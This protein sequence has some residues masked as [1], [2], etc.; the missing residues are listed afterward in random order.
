MYSVK[1]Y[2]LYFCHFE[3]ANGVQF[4]TIRIGACYPTTQSVLFDFF[5]IK[6]KKQ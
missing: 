6:D 4:A 2:S 1:F 5:D 3:I